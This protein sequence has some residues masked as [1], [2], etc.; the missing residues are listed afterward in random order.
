MAEQILISALY[1]C[2]R[3][4]NLFG[5]F[6]LEHLSA[7]HTMKTTCFMKLKNDHICILGIP[8]IILYICTS[9]SLV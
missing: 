3:C 2:R 4:G 7:Y 8:T 1:K 6:L 5:N 9:C